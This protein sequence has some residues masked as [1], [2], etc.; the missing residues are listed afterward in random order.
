MGIRSGI[1]TIGSHIIKAAKATASGVGKAIKAA[2]A[3]DDRYLGG[4]GKQTALFGARS[5]T[6][7]ALKTLD[8]GLSD[9]AIMEYTKPGFTSV[10][11]Y[12]SDRV[13]RR[14]LNKGIVGLTGNKVGQNALGKDYSNYTHN[15]YRNDL[16]TNFSRF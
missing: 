3:F 7:A 8:P 16:H 12:I 2:D 13:K 6:H 1:S 15:P 14:G 5:L 11:N 9:E 4:M 10:S